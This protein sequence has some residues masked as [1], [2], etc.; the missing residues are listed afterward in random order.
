MSHHHPAGGRPAPWRRL[1]ALVAL[2]VLALL[3]TG[4]SATS[5]GPARAGAAPGAPAADHEPYVDTG[6]WYVLVNRNSGKALDVYNLATNDGARITQ[7]SRNDQAQQRWQFV[8]S[9]GGHYRLR[10]GHSGK[11]LDV[12]NWSTAD[13]AS[14]VQWSDHNTANQQFRLSEQGDGYVRLI[15]RHS[16]KALEVQGAATTDGANIV[17]Y[18][19]WGGANQQWRLVPVDGGEPPDSSLPSSFQWSSSGVLAGP[20]SDASHDIVAIKDYSVVR[21]NG[22]WHVYAT[23]ASRSGGWNLVHFAA[24]DWSGMADARH[25][26]LDTASG[27]GTGYRAAPQVFYF[28]PQGLWYLV[29]Q[30]GLP[31]YSVSSDPGDPGSWS[32]P[33]N[34]MDSM[35]EIVR[36]NIGDGHWLDFWVICDAARCHLF[37]SDDN[38]HIYRAQTSLANFPRGFGDTVIALEDSNR[39]NLFEGSAVYRVG[40]TGTY[41][42]LQEAIGSDGRRWYRSF[43]STGLAGPW[44]PLAATESNPFARSNNV[45]FPSGAWTRDFSHGELIR[46]NS[47]QTLTIDPCRLQFLYQGIDPGA[48]GEYSQLPWRMGLLTQT[49]SA[50]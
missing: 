14:V 10:S 38:G 17:Q 20:K 29:Y 11:V 4:M 50:C 15:N 8:D 49:N 16:G 6:A 37:S 44:A 42:L 5:A 34:F 35:P 40:D 48:G 12:H 25:T 1:R 19:D 47:D 23:T 31:S 18:T 28:A 45:S 22:Q 9:G 32:A 39:N 2:V 24:P 30:T 7:W 13:G 26:F 43:T 33:R 46:A 27:V 3:A 21:H 36:Q 41:L